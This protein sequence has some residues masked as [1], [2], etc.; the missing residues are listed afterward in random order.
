MQCDALDVL[1]DGWDML[2][3]FPPC[4]HLAVSGACWFPEKRAD[5]RQQAALAFFLALARAPIAR[6][7]IENPVGIVSSLWH[8]PDQVIQPWQFGEDASKATCLW[9]KGLPRLWPTRIIRKARYANQTASGQNRLPPSPTRAR[10]RSRTY[11]GIAE[12]MA[13]Q[14][15]ECRDLVALAEASA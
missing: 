14:W 8:E 7:A 1:G 13:E 6:I 9:L 3:A 4:T 11:P 2:I 15:S 5:G 10:E 12:A